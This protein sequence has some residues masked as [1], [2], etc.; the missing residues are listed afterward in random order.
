MASLKEEKKKLE[1]S[2]LKPYT[3]DVIS[4]GDQ[5]LDQMFR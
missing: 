5:N 2:V 1:D 3:E 4:I